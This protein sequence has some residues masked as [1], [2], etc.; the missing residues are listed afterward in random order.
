MTQIIYQPHIWTR[1]WQAARGIL[2]ISIRT[3]CTILQIPSSLQAEAEVTC[4]IGAGL[5]CSPV[6]LYVERKALFARD[7]EA[8][9]PPGVHG[10]SELGNTSHS[11]SLAC[12]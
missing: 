6:E 5:C 12:I 1:T 10:L 8:L 9:A 3:N 11:W 4:R 2:R 7:K